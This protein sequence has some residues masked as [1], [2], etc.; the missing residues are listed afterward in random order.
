MP[1]QKVHCYVKALLD[2]QGRYIR[3]SVAKVV[4]A[5]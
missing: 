3:H 5:V 1:E 2:V 4:F